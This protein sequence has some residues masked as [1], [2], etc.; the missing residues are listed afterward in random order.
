MLFR[1]F[2][3]TDSPFD[4][5]YRFHIQK[6]IHPITAIWR[7][8]TS[9]S[10]VMTPG[11]FSTRARYFSSSGVNCGG[12]R[13]VAPPEININIGKTNQS[14]N[15]TTNPT[16]QNFFSILPSASHVSVPDFYFS[17]LI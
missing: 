3:L 12:H 13:K 11:N 7:I 10:P 9:D 2:D 6:V 5:L 14:K 1:Q 15:H 4:F 8:W 16:N 17:V